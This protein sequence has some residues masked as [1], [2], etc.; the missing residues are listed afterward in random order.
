M[1]ARPRG[2]GRSFLNSHLPFLDSHLERRL[3]RR[4]RV[5]DSR[6]PDIVDIDVPEFDAP[7]PSR[8]GDEVAL[9]READRADDALVGADLLQA[10][11]V[12]DGPDVDAPVEAAA[13]EELA[14]GRE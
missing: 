2:D 6:R 1:T 14:R 3:A 13:R 9:R 4:R 7:V 5:V 10:L 11:A 8:R 12:R